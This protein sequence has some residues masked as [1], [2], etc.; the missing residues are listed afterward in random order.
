MTFT[1]RHVYLR[2][3]GAFGAATGVEKWSVGLRFAIVG[4]DVEWNESGLLTF[5]NA[6]HS[7]L[8]TFHT[9]SQVNAGSACYFVNCSAACIGVDGK[10][11]PDGQET[12]FS[13][14]SPQVGTGSTALPWSAAVV[15]SLRTSRP[16]GYASNGR[17]YWP[18]TAA[19]IVGTTGRVNSG[20]VSGRVTAFRTAV[21]AMNTAAAVYSTNM[22]LAVMSSV[23]AGR[24]ALV[25]EIRADERLDN[26]ERR[27]NSAPAV[28]STAPIP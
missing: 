2:A 7:A 22:R 23:G 11:D 15:I 3:N 4:A 16:R 25:N 6:C 28:W 24:T 5:A 18:A 19:A 13:T 27:E 14:G 1:N 20:N 21:N 12:V 17:V 9:A 10:Y 8:V 26:V